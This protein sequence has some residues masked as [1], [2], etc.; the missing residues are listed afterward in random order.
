MVVIFIGQIMLLSITKIVIHYRLLSMFMRWHPETPSNRIHLAIEGS[1]G[2]TTIGLHMSADVID[3]GGRVLWIGM[4]MPNSERFPQ[5]FSHISPVASSRFHAMM[6]TGALDKSLETIISAAN[7]L[8]SVRLIVMDDWCD[9]SGKIPKF[10]LDLISRL[11]NSISS[12][13]R[14]L[15][16]SKGTVDAS[17]KRV[18][19]IFARAENHF[20][21]EGYEIWTF[22]RSS[23]GHHR[24]LNIGSNST[25]LKIVDS[26]LEC[27][28]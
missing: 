12:E 6:I 11:S 24:I 7:N 9:S 27:V 4:E 10:Q 22:S 26:G 13:I 15:L 3:N 17:G 20:V 25:T 18:G 23:N 5:L 28:T 8:P 16:I 2:G 1:V 19:E 14:L 21:N